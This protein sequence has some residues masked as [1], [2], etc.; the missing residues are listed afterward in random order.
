MREMPEHRENII[1]DLCE[2]FIFN[3]QFITYSL[4]NLCVEN[5]IKM[6]QKERECW[7]PKILKKKENESKQTSAPAPRIILKARRS[8]GPQ[9]VAP[10]SSDASATS[11]ELHPSR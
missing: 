5:Y 3:E 6:S 1:R 7:E 4:V 8:V 11:S 9:N 10:G 2:A